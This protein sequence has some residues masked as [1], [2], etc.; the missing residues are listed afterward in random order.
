M[1]EASGIDLMDGIWVAHVI[2]AVAARGV[3][4]APLLRE[5]SLPMVAPHDVTRRVPHRAFVSFLELAAQAVGDEHLGLRLGTAVD[6]RALGTLAYL[7][8]HAVDLGSGLAYAARYFG[9]FSTGAQF[10]LAHDGAEVQVTHRLRDPALRRLRQVNELALAVL[11]NGIRRS[12]NRGLTPCAVTFANAAPQDPSPLQAHF[13]APLAYD[14]PANCLTFP[15]A[16]LHLRTLEADARLLGILRNMCED[17][18]AKLSDGSSFLAQFDE[19]V[20]RL[21]PDGEPGLECVAHALA[22]SPRTLGRR[23][24]D[25]GTSYRARID[26]VRRHLA[27]VLLQDAT[28]PM[29]TVA[30]RLGFSETS[31]FSRAFRRWFDCPPSAY[32]RLARAAAPDRLPDDLPA[33]AKGAA[34]RATPPG[35]KRRG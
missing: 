16:W 10:S 14:Q 33:P 13:R 17:H 15:R 31:A 6:P 28:L 3:A 19:T 32:R 2:E 25:H 35:R 12:T 8:R 1:T 18:L 11:L 20:D 30:E 4:T 5:V 23:L 9:V 7:G 34:T 29:A 27:T 26:E 24:G 22:L 21:L